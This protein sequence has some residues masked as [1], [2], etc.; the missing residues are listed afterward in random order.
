M[1]CPH[2]QNAKTNPRA[3]KTKQGYSTFY[4]PQCRRTF[5]ERTGSRF[6][7]YGYPTDIIFLVVLWRLRY[8]LS[9]RDLSEMFLERGLEFSHETVRLWEA[10]FAPL[11]TQQLKAERR[12]N[13]KK[14]AAKRWKTD[15]TYLKVKGETVY[16]Y[17]A[18]DQFG[19]LVDVRLS[20]TRDLAA[21]EAFFKQAVQTVGHKPSQVTSDKHASYPK[22]IR[23]QLGLKVEHRTSQYL[24]NPMEADHRGIKSRYKPMKGFK[25]F[26]SAER[27]CS[28][29]DEQRNWFRY[30]E[31][32]NDAVPLSRQ[33]TL[34]RTRF[35]Y[36][37]NLFKAA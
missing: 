5:N 32:R 24:N 28:A 10:E 15:E 21:A 7:N 11:I 4:C 17:R 2:C 8:K 36:L 35:A 29:Y 19:N 1:T 20:K 16:L 25:S 3:K 18:I 13:L 12:H 34:F 9:L 31:F 27:F 6:N 30:R 22:A 23:K 14:M 26:K 33:R 37:Q